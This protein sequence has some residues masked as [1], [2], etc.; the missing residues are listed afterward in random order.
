[1]RI[2]CFSESA[3]VHR[4][5]NFF[6]EMPEWNTNVYSGIPRESVSER[7]S[8][9][10][11]SGRHTNTE[12]PRANSSRI[13][14]LYAAILSSS[15][16]W[17]RRGMCF[18]AFSRAC[19][20]MSFSVPRVSFG[21][22]VPHSEL[23]AVGVNDESTAPVVVAKYR[24]ASRADSIKAGRRNARAFTFPIL[25]NPKGSDLSSV[26]EKSAFS[27]PTTIA[28]TCRL[29]R[30]TDTRHPRLTSLSVK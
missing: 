13:I 3:L 30:G 14:P 5:A 29:R 8:I 1:M 17:I 20:D 9:S 2:G 4:A 6:P 10:V 11:I 12:P 18:V 15:A 22:F 26:F 19:V 16:D 7:R 27:T 25:R 24:A 23:S 28:G 21:M